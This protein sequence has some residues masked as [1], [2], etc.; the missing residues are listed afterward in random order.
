MP[1]LLDFRILAAVISAG[2]ALGIVVAGES[3]VLAAAAILL[4]AALA[5]SLAWR[6]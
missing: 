2:V 3:A 5:V 1:S 6:D 4:A